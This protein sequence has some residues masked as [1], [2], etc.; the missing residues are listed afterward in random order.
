MDTAWIKR[1]LKGPGKTRSGLGDA[2][3]IG[4]SGVSRLLA[5]KREIKAVELEI[6][7]RY[8][9]QRPPGIDLWPRVVASTSTA[10]DTS[11]SNSK[12][13]PLFA[14][15]GI[16]NAPPR[17]SKI[18]QLLS[19]DLPL[20]T[21][22][23]APPEDIVEDGENFKNPFYFNE[24]IGTYLRRAPSLLGASRAFAIR[25]PASNMA[26]RFVAGEIIYLNPNH[27]ISR[28]DFAVIELKADASSGSDGIQVNAG[29]ND[30]GISGPCF[31]Q[32]IV[33]LGAERLTLS[34]YSPIG[35]VSLPRA[36]VRSLF[37]IMNAS[38]LI[39]A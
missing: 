21:T 25:V 1:A 5:G 18:D 34:Q 22:R 23:M 6:I 2:L 29:G 20:H 24:G 33:H 17:I 26:P 28:G 19:R 7:C 32:K 11:L 37:R 12:S 3:G 16:E 36:C 4:P 13:A 9:G 38:E 10:R 8:L 14:P 30:P 39:E 35:E 27:P 31:V 15:R